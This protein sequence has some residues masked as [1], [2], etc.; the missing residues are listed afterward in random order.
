MLILSLRVTE[1]KK[2]LLRSNQI[3]PQSN[4]VSK[5]VMNLYPVVEHE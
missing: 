1:L 3:D 5:R 4:P 2:P